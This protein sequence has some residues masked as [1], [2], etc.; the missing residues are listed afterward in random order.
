MPRF[1]LRTLLIVLAISPMVLWAL[2][3]AIAIA[4]SEIRTAFLA[5]GIGT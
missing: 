3:L 5:R 4:L 1:S 2:W